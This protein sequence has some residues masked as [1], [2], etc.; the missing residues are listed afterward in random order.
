MARE[1]SCGLFGLREWP[2]AEEGGR[3]LELLDLHADSLSS[4]APLHHAA[5]WRFTVWLTQPSA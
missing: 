3:N 1:A 5:G 4:S 2:R